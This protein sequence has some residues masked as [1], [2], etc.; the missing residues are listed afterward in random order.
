[1]ISYEV[2]LRRVVKNEQSATVSVEAE[3]KEEAARIALSQA[4]QGDAEWSEE[5]GNGF[6]AGEV[7]VEEI[8]PITDLDDDL[9]E[10]F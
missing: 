6:I 1:M 4:E 5:L 2:R 9:S 10:E 8:I 7:Q 3:T